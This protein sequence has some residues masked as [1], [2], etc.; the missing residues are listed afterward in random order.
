MRL[1]FRVDGREDFAM[2]TSSPAKMLRLPMLLL[3]VGFPKSLNCGGAV[4][5]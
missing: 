3:V 1:G 2:K 4:T 5:W